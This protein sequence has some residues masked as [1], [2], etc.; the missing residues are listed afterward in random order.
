MSRKP[1]AEL[2]HDELIQLAGELDLSDGAAARA[3]SSFCADHYAR[4]R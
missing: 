2:T 1:V 3:H 4:N